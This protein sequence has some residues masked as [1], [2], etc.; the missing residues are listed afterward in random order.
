[1]LHRLGADAALTYYLF[2][3][4]DKKVNLRFKIYHYPPDFPSY[5]PGQYP[6]SSTPGIGAAL[7]GQR[8]PSAFAG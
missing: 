8:A 7:E 3:G 2:H 5:A 4:K 6:P 1:M